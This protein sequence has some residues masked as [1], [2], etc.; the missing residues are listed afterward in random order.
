M[1]HQLLTLVMVRNVNGNLPSA[2][3]GLGLGLANKSQLYPTYPGW[4]HQRKSMCSYSILYIW[5]IVEGVDY[6]IALLFMFILTNV[7]YGQFSP[8]W[9]VFFFGYYESMELKA[10]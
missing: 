10:C 3:A 6:F 1:L 9:G 4:E 2:M 5:V 7:P 8:V